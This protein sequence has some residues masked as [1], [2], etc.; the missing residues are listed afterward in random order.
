MNKDS[1]LLTI[2]KKPDYISVVRLTSSSISYKCGLNIDEI[3]DIKVAIGEA[4]VNSFTLC[5]NETISIKFEL[6]EE[7]LVIKVSDAR[8]DIPEDLDNARD[9][10]LGILIIKSLMDEVNF[11]DN[12]IEMTKYIV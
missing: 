5:A 8:E 12:G 2:P 1:V 9:R 3:E 7:K 4:C 10:E 6:E 11:D